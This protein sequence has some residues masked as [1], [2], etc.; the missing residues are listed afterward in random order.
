MQETFFFVLQKERKHEQLGDKVNSIGI[1]N[2]VSLASYIG[3]VIVGRNAGQSCRDRNIYVCVYIHTKPAGG[4]TNKK[5]EKL[6]L[7]AS[8]VIARIRGFSMDRA[9]RRGETLQH[10]C[11]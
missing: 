5:S 6:S 8:D 3:Y 11:H 4:L 1:F 7:P 9:E 2:T 10:L